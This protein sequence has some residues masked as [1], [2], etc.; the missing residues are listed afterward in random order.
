MNSLLL[1]ALILGSIIPIK[2]S[3]F[4]HKG[5]TLLEASWGSVAY[6]RTLIVEKGDRVHGIE[7]KGLG[8]R[9]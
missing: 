3:A 6:L 4:F 2:I 7:L 5:S 1:R 9:A 8:F